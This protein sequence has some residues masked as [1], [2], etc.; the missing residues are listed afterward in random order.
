MLGNDQSPGSGQAATASA[1]STARH[2]RSSSTTSFSA[3]L[4]AYATTVP[5]PISAAP[6]TAPASL[7]R[8]ADQQTPS[9]SRPRTTSV[10]SEPS[11]RRWP[12]HPGASWTASVSERYAETD[13]P[14]VTSTG[15]GRPRPPGDSAPRPAAAAP[16]SATAPKSRA[17]QWC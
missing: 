9:S 1:P 11:S 15:P 8:S 17:G 4:T 7:R 14:P 13:A 10:A 16:S 12:S 5:E 2:G 6:A 3:S